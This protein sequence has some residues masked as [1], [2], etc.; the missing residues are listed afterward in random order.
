MYLPSLQGPDD[1]FGPGHGG[2][3]VLGLDVL[4]GRCRVGLLLGDFPFG[5]VS[6]TGHVRPILLPSLQALLPFLGANR[7]NMEVGMILESPNGDH[8]PLAIKLNYNSTNNIAE[9]EA[10]ILGMEAA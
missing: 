3:P 5:F 8:T 4:A 7:K 2:W 9:Y 10:C 6:V 1:P